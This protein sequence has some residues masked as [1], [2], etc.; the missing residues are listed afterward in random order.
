MLYVKF[1][2]KDHVCAIIVMDLY[3]QHTKTMNPKGKFSHESTR[4]PAGA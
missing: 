4:G 3:P 1:L 2:Q